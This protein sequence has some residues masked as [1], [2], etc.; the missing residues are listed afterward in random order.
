[1]M[2]HRITKRGLIAK[3][4]R[5]ERLYEREA[6]AAAELNLGRLTRDY[7]GITT[8]APFGRRPSEARKLK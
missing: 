6:H 4:N 8:L 5:R 3:I 2:P 1:M 7:R